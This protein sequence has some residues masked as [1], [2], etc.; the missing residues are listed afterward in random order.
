M[1]PTT[2]MAAAVLERSVVYA[3]ATAFNNW[4]V[5]FLSEKNKQLQLNLWLIRK[6]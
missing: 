5:H 4:T 1:G 3:I 2:K 6:K